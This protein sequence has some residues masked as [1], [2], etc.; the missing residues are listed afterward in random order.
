MTVV[1]ADSVLLL[2]TAMNYVLLLGTARLAG[3]P[4]RRKRYALAAFLGG[5]YAVAVFLPE[6]EA[7]GTPLIKLSVGIFLSLIAF[8]REEKLFR[9]TLIFF[10][11][12]CALA[13]GVLGLSFFAK[14][15]TPMVN[16]ILFADV[17]GSVLLVAATAAYG[18]V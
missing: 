7:F 16:G 1:Y 9:L 2:N 3:R 10:G 17:N 11:L 4:L 5:V 12:S 15:K 8:G 14:S 6:M 18:L 13:G